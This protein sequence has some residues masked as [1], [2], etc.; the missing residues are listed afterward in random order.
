MSSTAPN[1]LRPVIRKLNSVFTLTGSEREAVERL[2]I[3]VQHL[4]A[5][6]DIVREGDRPVRCFA[7]LDAMA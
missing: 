5:D 6:Q 2:P 7:L 3:Q 4:R 1:D